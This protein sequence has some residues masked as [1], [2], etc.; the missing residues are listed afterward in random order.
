MIEAPYKHNIEL[1]VHMALRQSL[2]IPEGQTIDPMED[3]ESL[4]VDSLAT[5]DVAFR[6]RGLT[7]LD[8]TSEDLLKLWKDGHVPVTGALDHPNKVYRRGLHET[9]ATD[10]KH[11]KTPRPT[12]Q[13]LVEATRKK[14]AGRTEPEII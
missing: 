5:F 9:D 13:D 2:G 6:I 4:G 1:G 8:V 10:F 7:G 3:I 11:D 12:V 14:A